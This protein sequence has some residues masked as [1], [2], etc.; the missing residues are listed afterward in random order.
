MKI[1]LITIGNELLNGKIQDKNA[2]WLAKF[3]YQHNLSLEKVQV[4]GDE[5]KQFKM[6]ME[7]AL[8]NGDVVL[9][10]GGLGPTRDDITKRM[11][12]DIFRKPIVKNEQAWEITESHYARF[13]KEFTAKNLD[14]GNIPQDFIPFS[15][16][17]GFAPGLGYVTEENKVIAAMP[18]VPS[19]FKAML[20]EVIF[21]FIQE[22]L[23]RP[24]SFFKHVIVKTYKIPEAKIFKELCPN[25]WEQ[26]EPFGELSSL[27]HPAGVDVGVKLQ[28][29]SQ[30]AIDKKEREIIDLITATALKDYIWHIGPESIEEVIIQKAKEK[31]LTIGFAESCT[32]GLC[33]D[34]MTNVS[35]SSSVFWGSVVSYSNDVKSNVLKV[36]ADTLKQY[37][38]VS[39][40]TALEMAIGA[41]EALGVDIAVSTTGIA[42]PGGGSEEKPVGTVGIGFAT[43][44]DSRSRLHRYYGDRE[45]LKFSFSQGALFTLMD[46]INKL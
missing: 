2:H 22:K 19:E 27:P 10:S 1:Q 42:G 40:E 24:K 12:A 35:G 6:A 9:T 18:G 31:N 11:L 14:Y 17:V 16:P 36:K 39:E 4:V 43:K 23:P 37:G 28:E 30:Q 26:L 15:N 21:P 32:G 29:E 20:T 41:R 25:L 3:C 45:S 44:D 46:R 7:H 8:N 13:H 38:A 5:D 33:A 34:R